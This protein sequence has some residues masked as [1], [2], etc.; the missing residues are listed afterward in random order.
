MVRFGRVDKAV[1]PIRA[2]AGKDDFFLLILTLKLTDFRIEKLPFVG[3]DV[4]TIRIHLSFQ[5]TALE[6]A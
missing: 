6:V 3:E 5:K 2:A 4:F 1:H